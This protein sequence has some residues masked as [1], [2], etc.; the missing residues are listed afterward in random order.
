MNNLK[1]NHVF[2]SLCTLCLGGKIFMGLLLHLVFG[3]TFLRE[4]R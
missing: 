1:L 3:I 2:F 4:Q